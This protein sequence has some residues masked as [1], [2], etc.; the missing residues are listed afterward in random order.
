VL[1]QSPG[2]SECTQ[3]QQHPAAAV[4]RL[5]TCCSRTKEGAEKTLN[6]ALQRPSDVE[7]QALLESSVGEMPSSTHP[8]RGFAIV[9]APSSRCT[10]EV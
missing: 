9:N 2:P 6:E 3:Q 5:V 8:Y 10:I 7:L 1:L 4:P